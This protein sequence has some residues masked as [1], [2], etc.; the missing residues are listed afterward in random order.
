MLRRAAPR[1]P[2]QEQREAYAKIL[3]E[4]NFNAT[5]GAVDWL[6]AL[7]QWEVPCVVCSDRLAREQ[8]RSAGG[9]R[10]GEAERGCA[11]E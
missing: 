7:N 4:F 3:P 5:P 11:A 10:G 6:T 8:V 1:F 2:A 9:G